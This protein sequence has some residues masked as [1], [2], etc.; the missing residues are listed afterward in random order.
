MIDRSAYTAFLEK[1]AEDIDI[2]PGKY[3]EAVDRYEAVGSWLECGS[4]PGSTDVPDIYPQGSFRLG[5]VVR[6]IRAGVETEFDID[7]VC[8]LAIAKSCT[9]PSTVKQMVGK[10]LGE[11]ERYRKM[12]DKEGKRCW[13]LHYAEK[14]GIGF[15]LDVLPSAPDRQI[16]QDTSIAITHRQ[17]S[18]YRWLA[19]NPRGYGNWFDKKNLAA[20]MRVRDQQKH[21]ILARAST[22]YASVDEVPDRLV[23]TPLQ[24][25]IQIMKRH[26][27]ELFNGKP[28]AEYAPI[29]IIVTTLAAH[30]YQG[31]TDICAALT[32]IISKLNGHAGLLKNQPIEQTLASLQLIQR[33]PDGKW[34]IA[35][36]VKRE[37]NFADR[38][39]ED[40]HARAH[41]FFRW[42]DALRE[43]LVDILTENRLETT[44]RRLGAALGV[45]ATTAHL[46]MISLTGAEASPARINIINAA[47][48]WKH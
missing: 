1:F 43:D 26:R 16:V 13:T 17:W 3:K 20:F 42:V 29:S 15:H 34:Y 37:E 4:Y 46:G 48:P 44:K 8:E 19:S 7:L 25:T 23:R 6:P 14:D 36:P 31:E 40:D 12:L 38:W 41:A 33:M 21:S 45:S 24:R 39:Y 35:N 47:S 5:T 28:D 30:L 9:D 11:H 18:G 27:D 32:A 22:V 2:P 10:R